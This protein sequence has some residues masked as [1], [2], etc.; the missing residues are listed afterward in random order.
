MSDA[1][2]VRKMR[3]K[4]RASEGKRKKTSTEIK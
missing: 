1:K 3:E 2:M 4:E